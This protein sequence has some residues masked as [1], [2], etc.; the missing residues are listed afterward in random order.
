MEGRPRYGQEQPDE[1]DSKESN[2]KKKRRDRAALGLG[3]YIDRAVSGDRS[4]ERDGSSWLSPLYERVARKKDARILLPP[5]ESVDDGD[6]RA[7]K[8]EKKEELASLETSDAQT[9]DGELPTVVESEE[10]NN[11]NKHDVLEGIDEVGHEPEFAAERSVED[12]RDRDDM[13][14]IPA[15][16]VIERPVAPT[17]HDIHHEVSS[18]TLFTS[19]HTT[20]VDLSPESSSEEPQAVELKSEPEQIDDEPQ[21]LNQEPE[22]VEEILRRRTQQN[23]IEHVEPA[24]SVR[25]ETN[26]TMTSE[27][28]IENHYYSNPNNGLH[29]LN[30]ALARR[31]DSRNRKEAN[32]NIAQSNKRISELESTQKEQ[33]SNLELLSKQQKNEIKHPQSKMV[34]ERIKDTD[35]TKVVN[36]TM[37]PEVLFDRHNATQVDTNDGVAQT[38]F[39]V[40]Q[41]PNSIGNRFEMLPALESPDTYSE[42]EFDRKHEI[43]DVPGDSSS[44][45]RQQTTGQ[46]FDTVGMSPVSQGR[47]APDDASRSGLYSKE[48]GDMKEMITTG[49][50]GVV[51]GILVF[52]VIY[53]VTR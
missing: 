35:P 27:R 33:K 12:D 9:H 38:K 15:W 48:G 39:E 16:P 5:V 37:N 21:L 28:T 36:A 23:P 26:P 42:L 8:E 1:S 52:I 11:E 25:A 18:D 2:S 47:V 3:R 51:A 50:W 4:T 29:L 30:Y 41:K 17:A 19:E 49:A 14:V 43:M 10:T 31:R 13:P 32:K 46:Y 7:I 40:E 6:A 53:V 45:T 22:S 24:G 34:F 44:Q 20:E